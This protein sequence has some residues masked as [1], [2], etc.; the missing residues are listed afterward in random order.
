MPKGKE[1]DVTGNVPKTLMGRRWIV[2]G[3][4]VTSSGCLVGARLER[5][6]HGLNCLFETHPEAHSECEI[7][8]PSREK[9]RSA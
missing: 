1:F 4:D 6:V 9:Y 7:T 2:S 3:S 8:F 5:I